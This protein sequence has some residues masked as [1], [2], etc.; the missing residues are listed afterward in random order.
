[1]G[2]FQISKD[3]TFTL[4]GKYYEVPYELAGKKVTVALT[5]S[6]RTPQ[7]VEDKDGNDIGA[8]FALDTKSNL[9]RK[10]QRPQVIK[11][12]KSKES[13][14]EQALR[15]RQQRYGVDK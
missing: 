13:L 3:G 8:I 7:Y 6:Q 11:S 9:H 1:M 10:R 12:K 2:S 4:S 5:P 15:K 14:I